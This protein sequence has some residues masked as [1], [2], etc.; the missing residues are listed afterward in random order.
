[1]SQALS[2]RPP[3]RIEDP[4]EPFLREAGDV[5]VAFINLTL[6]DSE[7]ST[8]KAPHYPKKTAGE[9]G[10]LRA[11]Q[12]EGP[13]A[14]QPPTAPQSELVP[15]SLPLLGAEDQ[16]LSSSAA[17]GAT[18]A[19]PEVSRQVSGVILLKP[20]KHSEQSGHTCAEYTVCTCTSLQRTE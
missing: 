10:L 1:M 12:G 5:A 4:D 18:A 16:Q 17:P 11:P 7:S 9:P 19:R 20:I 15:D 3:V 2:S 14:D 6:P 8:K 13:Q